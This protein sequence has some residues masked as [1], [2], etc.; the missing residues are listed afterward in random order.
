MDLKNNNA[1]LRV[2]IIIVDIQCFYSSGV[3][4][5]TKDL[6][7]IFRTT[8]LSSIRSMMTLSTTSTH[9]SGSPAAPTCF[10]A[11]AT[12]RPRAL[13]VLTPCKDQ[14]VIAPP[15]CKQE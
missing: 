5:E 1:L 2:G 10:G 6:S 7:G 4:C 14:Q 15:G 8:M 12:T 11:Q 9:L 13:T 3:C